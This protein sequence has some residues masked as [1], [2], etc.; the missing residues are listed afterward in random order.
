MKG[1]KGMEMWQLVFLILAIILL[2]FFLAWYGLLGKDLA[3]LLDKLGE[4]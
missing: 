3:S 1:K 2:L 4:L